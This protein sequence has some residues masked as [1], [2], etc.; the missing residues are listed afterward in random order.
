MINRVQ[1][2]HNYKEVEYFQRLRA[3]FLSLFIIILLVLLSC[4][5]ITTENGQKSS[6]KLSSKLSQVLNKLESPEEDTQKQ[7]FLP[8]R[9]DED[10]RVQIYVNLNDFNQENLNQ[11]KG[12]G[13]E[14]EIYDEQQKI[15]QGWALPVDIRTMCQFDFVKSI[16]LPNYVYKQ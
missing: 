5:E 9:V 1:V 8:A 16:D 3:S 6:Q 11:L 15:V 13:L 12:H 7:A 4:N 10:G 2:S 14:I